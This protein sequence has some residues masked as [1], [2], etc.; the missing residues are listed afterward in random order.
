LPDFWDLLFT[1]GYFPKTLGVLMAIAGLSY[2][3][4]SFTQ[5]LAPTYAGTIFSILG[6]GIVILPVAHC[7]GRE[8]P[9]VE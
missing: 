7:E 8:R 6:R 4:I 3:S 5:I 9:E 1:S 2:L